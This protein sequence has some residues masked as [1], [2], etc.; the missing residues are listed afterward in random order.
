MCSSDLRA[1]ILEIDDPLLYNTG[2]GRRRKERR[3]DGGEGGRE[4]KMTAVNKERG[5]DGERE[6]ERGKGVGTG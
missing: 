2:S 1:F 4:K 5:W 6:R 3:K